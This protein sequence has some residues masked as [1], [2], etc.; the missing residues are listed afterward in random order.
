MQALVRPFSVLLIITVS[1]LIALFL[2]TRSIGLIEHTDRLDHFLQLREL[3]A[4]L[5][6]Q[7]LLIAT[8]VQNQYDDQVQYRR[9]LDSL[10]AELSDNQSDFH[11]GLDSVS[12]ELL[13]QYRHAQAEK[14]VATE[15]IKLYAALIRNALLFM[16]SLVQELRDDEHAKRDES[17]RL[18]SQLFR[19]HLFPDAGVLTDLYRSVEHFQ[20]SLEDPH[21]A[22]VTF[23]AQASQNLRHLNRLHHYRDTFNQINSSELLRELEKS[24]QTHYHHRSRHAEAFT[25]TL[26]LLSILLMLLLGGMFQRLQQLNA[27]SEQARTRLQDAVNSL[28]EAFALFDRHGNLVLFNQRWKSFYPWLKNI[29]SMNWST[30]QKLNQTQGVT[31]STEIASTLDTTQNYLEHTPDGRWYQASNNPTAEGGIASVR[32]NITETQQTHL[33]LR[34]LGRALEQSPTAVMITDTEGLIEYINPKLTEMTGYSSDELLGQNNNILKSGEMPASLFIEMWNVLR[35]GKTWTGQLLNRKKDGSFFWDSTSISPLRNDGGEISHFIAI[36][37]DITERLNAEEQLRMVAAVF[38]T[39]NEAIMIADQNGLIK[40][41]NRAFER[42]TGYQADEVQGCNPNMLSSGRHDRVFY[43]HMWETLCSTGAWSGEIWNRRKDGSVY[44]EWLSISALHDDDGNITEFVSVF[45]DITN[46]K[47][48]EAHIRHQAYYD[49]LTQLPNRN[50]LLDRLEVAIHTA[51]RDGQTLS[52]M[53]ID[54]DRFK[55]VNDTLG[56]EYGDELL[57]QVAKRLVK[58]VRESDTVARFGGDEFVILLHNIHSEREASLVAEKVIKRISEPFSLAGREIVIGASIGL[59]LFPGESDEPDTLLR[60]ADLAMYRAKQ[61]G[62][63]RFQF[64]TGSLQEQANI[65]MEMEQDLRVALEKGQLEIYYQPLIKAQSGK[66]TG[67]EALLR[68]HHPTIGMIPP[69]QF[70]PLA[71][72]TGLIGPIGEWVL[73]T[74]CHQVSLWHQQGVKLYL[75]VNISGRQRG[76]GLN[77]ALLNKILGQTQLPASQLVLEITEGMLLDNSDATI[78]WLQSFSDLGVHLAIDDFGTGYSALSYLKRF[79]INMLKI[80]REFIS[81]LTLNN[82][83]A[84]L[85]KAI[86]SMARSLNLRLIAEGV[87][88]EAQRLLLHQLGCEYLQ[89]YHFSKPLP[90]QSFINWLEDYIATPLLKN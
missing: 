18:M 85:V 15:E 9:A 58:C 7:T 52:V 80:D 27:R 46:R 88:T 24:Y 45:S 36:K 1:I 81:E 16:P 74:A 71:E 68:W 59:S 23:A 21:P 53:F 4:R 78:E 37:E 90:A 3:G 38:E 42:I 67:V 19:Y 73:E 31:T 20:N 28:S 5:D 60:N 49:A 25:L 65:L 11:L 56:H 13:N 35:E 84:L 87:E 29:E 72:D 51:E 55:Y 89:G 41:V 82:E 77:A 34:Q 57:V 44:P 63:N 83:D 32:T 33:R 22:L 47:E 66:V 30:Q 76:L 8:G 54:L 17:A 64:F 61:T 26:L 69:D 50:L 2:Q 75:S 40:V 12:A 48:A 62:R 39:S 70:I 14:S 79:P 10:L 86:I 6:E 43:E